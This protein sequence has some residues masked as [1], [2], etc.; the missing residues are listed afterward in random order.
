M[1]VSAAMLA[2]SA[3]T[4]IDRYVRGMPKDQVA[5]GRPYLKKLRAMRMEIGGALQN[6]SVPLRKG[7]GSQAQWY[8]GAQK[9]VF[10]TRDNLERGTFPWRSMRDGTVVDEDR[11][12]RNDLTISEDGN[13]RANK[14]E[15]VRLTNLWKE[16]MQQLVL[17]FDEAY[18]QALNR[19]G[20]T[21]TEAIKGRDYLFPTDP[22]T[23]TV[24]GQDSATNIWWR[25]RTPVDA[26]DAPIALTQ[27]T[28]INGLEKFSR[29]CQ[30]HG[31]RF[32]YID[33]GSTWIDTF[34]AAA[35]ASGEIQRYTVLATSGQQPQLDPGTGVLADGGV[36]TGLHWKGVPILWNPVFDVLDTVESPGIQWKS[37]GYFQNCNDVQLQ[38]IR[39]YN[40]VTSKPMTEIDSEAWYIIRRVK[41][42]FVCDRRNGSG[43]SWVPNA[44]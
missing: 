4:S 12:V 28:L 11:L 38:P 24:G 26:S 13:V 35:K 23:G 10:N 42:A 44:A 8:H 37:R 14:D 29:E 1:P 39:G 40:E 7:Y 32:D 15:A 22:R 30:R 36:E 6:I 17:G 3:K 25:S 19:S 5:I 31:G 2:V 16:L 43:V 27:A 20:T 18:D 21:S 9:M 34:R 33:A 41:T